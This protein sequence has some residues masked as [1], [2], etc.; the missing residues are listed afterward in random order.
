MGTMDGGGGNNASQTGWRFR[1]DDGDGTA[2]DNGSGTGA[3]YLA[4]INTP[5][6][7]VFGSDVQIRP[8]ICIESSAETQKFQ[9]QRRLNPSGG[10]IQVNTSSTRVVPAAS[11]HFT[12]GNTI[13]LTTWGEELST[14]SWGDTTNGALLEDPF[15]STVD[16]T[17]ASGPDTRI[18]FE[19]CV[20][21][22][23]EDVLEI[24][25]VISFRC[26]A[27]GL[28]FSGG[29]DLPQPSVTFIAGP[30]GAKTPDRYQQRVGSRIWTR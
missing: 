2:W 17:F 27:A 16:C 22:L 20:K 6:E 30:G 10:W 5:I 11:D 7:V 12:A 13:D 26:V 8:R 23:W 29:Y 9:L 15:I 3:S 24:G 21:F 19:M 18:E 1:A 14:A 28:I 25:D 4:A